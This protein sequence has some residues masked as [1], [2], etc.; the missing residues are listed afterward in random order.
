MRVSLPGSR[1]GAA[2]IALF[3]LASIV[4]LRFHGGFVLGDDAEEFQLIRSMVVDGVGFEGHLRYRVPMW[5]FNYL[6]ERAFG[7]YEAAFFLPTW[8]LS[9]LLP[10][11]AYLTLRSAAYGRG[12]ALF[13]GALV[14]FSPFEVLI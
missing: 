4:R 1:D 11:L 9:S 5:L 2:A 6:S 8:L 14:A 3:L 13:A 12:A 7:N 10:V